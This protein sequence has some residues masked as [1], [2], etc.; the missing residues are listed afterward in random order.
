MPKLK[1]DPSPTPAPIIMVVLPDEIAR[2]IHRQLTQLD[3]MSAAE[4][5]APRL[6]RT[7]PQRA[8]RRLSE[9]VTAAPSPPAG[10]IDG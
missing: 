6:P 10:G 8:A 7:T 5:A 3:Q 4:L 9:E 1:S 2:Q